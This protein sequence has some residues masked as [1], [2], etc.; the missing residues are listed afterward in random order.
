MNY[1]NTRS[2][3]YATSAQGAQDVAK[4]AVSYRMRLLAEYGEMHD[5]SD[6]QGG[7]TDEEAA[8]QCGLLGSCYWKRCGELRADG[9]IEFTGDTRVGV[10]GTSR[11]ISRL[12]ERG[13]SALRSPE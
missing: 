9:L 13:R 10:A 6:G 7:L 12:T 5:I 1:V 11:N 2:G 3:D 8:Y 4:R